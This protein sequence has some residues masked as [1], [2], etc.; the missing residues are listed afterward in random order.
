MATI[1]AV[2]P[3]KGYIYVRFE[4]EAARLC[5]GIERALAHHRTKVIKACKDNSLRSVLLDL[6]GLKGSITVL[7]EHLT[8]RIIVQQWPP[9]SQVAMV[10]P[11]EYLT[12]KGEHLERVA[13]N[14][15]AALR[16]FES[17]ELAKAWL[18]SQQERRNVS[19]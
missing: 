12:D 10:A 18:T 16:I 8:A 17:V 11:P 15:G 5:T 9:G 6:T 7:E 3:E 14:R 2:T 13:Q 1:S 19:G 4:G